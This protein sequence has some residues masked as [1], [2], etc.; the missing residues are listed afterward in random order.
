[1]SE[2]GIA[3]RISVRQ[4]QSRRARGF[5]LVE[6]LVVISIIV[7]LASLMVP[8]ILMAREAARRIQC[9]NNLYNLA[10]AAKQFEVA[11]GSLPASRTFWNDAKYR[12][13]AAMPTSWTAPNAP[14][15]T[16]SWVH[17]LM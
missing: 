15:Q 3:M 14:S 6:L 17:E 1:M 11:R 2:G 12:A 5:T 13:S 9:G 8:A 7:M 16:L 10:L 4:Q